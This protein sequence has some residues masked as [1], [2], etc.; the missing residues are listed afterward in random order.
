MA[1]DRAE[2]ARA[3]A[4]LKRETGAL[5]LAHNYQRPEIYAVADFIGDSLELARRAADA[6]S[7]FIV[8]CGV[9][10]MAETVKLLNPAARVVLAEPGAGCQMADMITAEA[11][12]A[13]RRELGDVTVVA[14]VN[15][16]A[17]V[18]AGAD[19]CCTSA[20]AVPVVASVPAGRRILFVPDR[21]L[22][23]WAARES[24]R[25]LIA[26]PGFCYVHATFTVEDVHRARARWPRARVIAHPECP[27]AVI[28]AADRVASTGGMYRLAPELGEVVLGTEAGMCARIARDFPAVTCRPLR[29]TALCV[30]MKRTTLESVR[31]ALAGA[32]AEVTIPEPIAGPARQAIERM[33]ALG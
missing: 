1:A 14:Y 4:R 13:K 28:D 23:A 9:R 30:N 17:D 6:R 24:G 33:L 3:V 15:T 19:I 10:F 31:R 22:A 29:R 32:V 16:P 8:F 26:W 12:A 18:K 2:P 25:E 11:L 5:I 27:L 7:R 20:N 21:N